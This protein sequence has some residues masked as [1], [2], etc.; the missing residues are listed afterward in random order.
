MLNYDNIPGTMWWK[1][2][3][4]GGCAV[5]AVPCVARQQVSSSLQFLPC[6]GHFASSWPLE[7]LVL[8]E[9]VSSRRHCHQAET[10]IHMNS[11]G[12]H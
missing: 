2:S 12:R 6:C 7:T 4:K 1:D 3:Y 9:A 5:Q 8:P 10:Q 11:R